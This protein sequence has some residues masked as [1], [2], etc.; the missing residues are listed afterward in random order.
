MQASCVIRNVESVDTFLLSAAVPA[1]LLFFNRNAEHS[2]SLCT[3]WPPTKFPRQESFLSYVV[4]SHMVILTGTETRYRLL[5]SSPPPP[6]EAGFKDRQE[7][8]RRMVLYG[9]AKHF[10]LGTGHRLSSW[11]TLFSVQARGK[12]SFTYDVCLGNFIRKPVVAGI[13]LHLH[14]GTPETSCRN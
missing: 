7:C 5:I 4:V 2:G 12:T 8:G 10:L 14:A 3:Q 13:L 9:F 11:Q 6:P 1:S